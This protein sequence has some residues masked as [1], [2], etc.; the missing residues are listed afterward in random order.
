MANLFPHPQTQGQNQDQTQDQIQ[1]QTP[2]PHPCKASVVPLSHTPGQSRAF[3]Y[4]VS[5]PTK[6]CPSAQ[7]PWLSLQSC[8][9]PPLYLRRSAATSELV[10]NILCLPAQGPASAQIWS[11][12]TGFRG[13]PG[14][15][16]LSLVHL[17]PLLPILLDPPAL[18]YQTL[19]FSLYPVIPLVQLH[20][21]KYQIFLSPPIACGLCLST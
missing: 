19:N 15:S 9:C 8:F 11:Q 14:S 4:L 10:K 16:L 2:G 6:L 18:F 21:S 13:L 1:D 5:F 17:Q 12:D 20:D 3:E 7:P